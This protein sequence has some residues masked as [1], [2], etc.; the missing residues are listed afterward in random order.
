MYWQIGIQ[1]VVGFDELLGE[2][3]GT[4]VDEGKAGAFNHQPHNLQ[5]VAL[6]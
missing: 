1:I 6:N 5:D 4:G 2:C 3:G